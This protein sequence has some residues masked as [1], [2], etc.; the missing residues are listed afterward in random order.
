MTQ[1][2]AGT[3][4][5][6]YNGCTLT[7]PRVNT[8]F[9]LRPVRDDALRTVIG[10]HYTV[11]VNAIITDDDSGMQMNGGDAQTNIAIVR[12]LLTKDGGALVISGQGFGS[13]EV[14]TNSSNRDLKYGPKTVYCDIKQIGSVNAM[15]LV[16]IF[17]FEISEC[18]A[19]SQNGIL[20][21]YRAI[22]Y[23]VEYSIDQ[24]G[25]TTRTVS[26]YIELILNRTTPGGVFIP[27][28]ADDARQVISPLVPIWFQRV[29]QRYMIS[30]DKSRIDF[31]ITDREQM[32]TNGYPEG[33]VAIEMKHRVKS[34]ESGWNTTFCNISGYVEMSKPYP[35]VWAWERALMIIRE[36]I[37]YARQQNDNAVILSSVEISENIFSKVVEFSV[38]YRILKTGLQHMLTDSGLFRP[39]ESTNYTSWANSLKEFAWHERGVARLKHTPQQ[40]RIVDPCN[41]NPNTSLAD[42]VL[43]LQ[44]SSNLYKMANVCPPK[45]R[46]Y[47]VFQNR[48]SIEIEGGA[49]VEHPTM[50]FDPPSSENPG[51]NIVLYDEGQFAAPPMDLIKGVVVQQLREAPIYIVMRGRATR[52]CYPC[53][54][55]DLKTI[56]G[57]ANGWGGQSSPLSNI[58][59]FYVAAESGTTHIM[60]GYVGGLKTYSAT[61]TLRYKI[62]N[63]TAEDLKNLLFDIE[64]FSIGTQED[65]SGNKAKEPV[66]SGYGV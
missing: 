4:Y 19:G 31:T 44:T 24:S 62:A 18:S 36:R 22:N 15:E 40:D 46:S 53:Q 60:S 45:N 3:G 28:T 17:E 13:L 21:N 65:P 41:Q 52:V 51:D 54:F 6:S 2:L 57:T 42:E 50:P 14:N 26:G 34:S 20:G 48:I 8:S 64:K 1:T 5:I 7:G 35:T 29:D 55:P 43:P 56:G 38:D 61:W 33:V 47:T 16:W 32:G 39:L 58:K 66:G 10:N 49:I 11:T 59:F 23:Q 25:L 27:Y 30:A 63:Y 37:L 12:A 9:N